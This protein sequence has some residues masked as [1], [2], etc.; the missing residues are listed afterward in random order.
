[1]HQFPVFSGIILWINF[2]QSKLTFNHRSH[3]IY[4]ALPINE[5][6]PRS[7]CNW[8]TEAHVNVLVRLICLC[9][10]TEQNW[11]I[12]M[13]WHVKPEVTRVHA[14]LHCRVT[15]EQKHSRKPALAYGLWTGT[16]QRIPTRRQSPIVS[17][18]CLRRLCKRIDRPGRINPISN[19]QLEPGL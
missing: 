4:M 10:R 6:L 18:G 16:R 15:T 12:D 1:M 11:K 3:Y 5:L 14:P 7:I 13:L 9:I 19:S 2:N 8:T 17:I